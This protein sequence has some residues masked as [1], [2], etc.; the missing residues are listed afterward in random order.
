MRVNAV[1]ELPGLVGRD[2]RL[3]GVASEDAG[4]AWVGVPEADAVFDGCRSREV[5]GEAIRGNYPGYV[6]GRQ[7]RIAR[8]ARLVQQRRLRPQADCNVQYHKFTT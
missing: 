3:P 4:L 7:L 8:E 1:N 5:K 6:P 2:G